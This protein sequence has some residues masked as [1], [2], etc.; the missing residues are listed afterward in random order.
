M[1]L[2]GHDDYRFVAVEEMGLVESF[3]PRLIAGD[4][5]IMVYVSNFVSLHIFWCSILLL[6]IIIVVS[7]D[8][9]VEV[10]FSFFERKSYFISGSL[11]LQEISPIFKF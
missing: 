3:D 11:P 1:T 10:M 5:Q 9:V 7:L 2:H 8:A 6:N 4:I